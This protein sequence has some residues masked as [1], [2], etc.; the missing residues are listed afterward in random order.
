M[1][2]LSGRLPNA[3]YVLLMCKRNAGVGWRQQRPKYLPNGQLLA[4]PKRAAS[5]RSC[6]LYASENF[7]DE[8]LRSARIFHFYAR[9]PQ[10]SI[11]LGRGLEMDSGEAEAARSF[12]IGQDVVHINGFL[13]AHLAGLERLAKDERVRLA[14]AH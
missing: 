4:L 6:N 7:C 5:T 8:F 1:A 11:K 10:V 9:L 12:H 14:G 13:G 3:V 2:A